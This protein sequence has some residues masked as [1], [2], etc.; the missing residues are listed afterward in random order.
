M[1]VL[2]GFMKRHRIPMSRRIFQTN[3]GSRSRGLLTNLNIF[4]VTLDA[5]QE[6]Q[7]ERGGKPGLSTDRR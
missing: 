4:G 6:I 3:L 7:P 5:V 1:V 2:S